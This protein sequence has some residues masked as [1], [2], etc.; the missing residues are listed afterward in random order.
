MGQT[1]EGTVALVTGASSGIGEETAR[2]LAARARR[3]RSS[4]AARTGWTRSRGEIG[5]LA[6][7]ADVT[8]REQ[9]TA[10][11][12]RTAPELGRLDIVI[13][14]AG[15]MLL[16]PIVDAPVEEWD[17]MIALNLKGA[18]LRRARG[19]AAPAPGRGQDPRRVADLVNVSSVAGRR[20]GV[21]GGVYQPDQARPRRVQRGAAP[22]GDR[23]L[24]ALLADGA[25]RHRVRAHRATC[26]REVRDQLQSRRSRPSLQTRGHR[27]RDRLHGHAPTALAIN[28]VLVRPTQQERRAVPSTASARLA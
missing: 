2:A 27:R 17:R 4:R 21:G 28:E 15:V 22:G 26:A 3:S 18:A 6:I 16:G 19:A 10:A 11:V 14:N 13:N 24:R 8:E 12:E 23:P 1:L 9:A 25:R 20:V 7:E 5:G